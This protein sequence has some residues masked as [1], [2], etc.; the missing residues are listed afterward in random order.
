MAFAWRCLDF[1]QT[2]LFWGRNAKALQINSS[3]K[4]ST[5]SDKRGMAA[6]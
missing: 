5:E 2:Q 3:R 6:D 4:L 1:S